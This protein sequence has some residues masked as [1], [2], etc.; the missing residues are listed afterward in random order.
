LYPMSMLNV[1]NWVI[2]DNIT[3]TLITILK[4][5]NNPEIHMGFHPYSQVSS[6]FPSFSN[7][8]YGSFL[9]NNKS[10]LLSFCKGTERGS[11]KE[12]KMGA[13]VKWWESPI[14]NEWSAEYMYLKKTVKLKLKSKGENQK[15]IIL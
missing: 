5:N 13:K 2:A 3:Y 8:V 15:S 4:L 12:K 9:L 10:I 1:K 7:L 6:I 14:F 11:Q